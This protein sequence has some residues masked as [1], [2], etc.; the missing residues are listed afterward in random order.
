MTIGQVLK[1]HL[2][3][4]HRSADLLLFDLFIIKWMSAAT[5]VMSVAIFVMA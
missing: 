2:V 3:P 1:R 5:L 4:P